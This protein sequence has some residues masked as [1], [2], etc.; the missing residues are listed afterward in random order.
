MSNVLKVSVINDGSQGEKVGIRVGDVITSY[1]GTP[2]YSN[3]ELSNAIHNAKA[4][5]KEHIDIVIIRGEQEITMNVTTDPLGVDCIEAPAEKSRSV[6]HY[7]DY[8]S[9]YGT[10]RTVS[11]FISFLGWVVFVGGLIAAFTGMT[12]GLQG[13]YSGE[14]S[15]VALLPGIGMAVAGLFLVAAGQVTRATVDNADH[16]REILNF[17][18]SRA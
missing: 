15:T 3:I 1:N 18:K 9:K 2:V 5:K 13:R 17:I 12:G 8:K 14:V 4:G 10:A 16:T 11:I 7:A 6:G